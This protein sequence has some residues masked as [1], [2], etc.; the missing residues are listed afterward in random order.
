M[1]WGAKQQTAAESGSVI[2]AVKSTIPSGSCRWYQ[3]DC[4][5]NLIAKLKAHTEIA[6]VE[7]DIVVHATGQE[8]AWGVDRIDADLVWSTNTG[9]GVNVAILDTGIDYDHPDLAGNIAGGINY[10]G[11]WWKDGSTNKAY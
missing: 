10:T 5:K 2:S 11:G 3:P 7:D 8:T 1:G 6:Y 9:K 4:L